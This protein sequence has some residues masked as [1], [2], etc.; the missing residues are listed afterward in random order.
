MSTREALDALAFG[1]ARGAD[2]LWLG[3]GDATLRKDLLAIVSAAKI[4]GYVRIKLQTNGM[5]LSYADYARRAIEAGITEVSFSIKAATAETHD[6]YTLTPG[7]HALMLQGIER[8]R[9]AGLLLEA[10][11]LV[12]RGT[13]SE[14]PEIVRSYHARGI[15]RFRIWLLS[16][17]D[18][19]DPEVKSEVPRISDVIPE[20]RAALALG[21]SDAPD[22]IQSLHTPPCT[23]GAELARCRFFAP[24]LALVV[25]NPGGH[26]FRLEES[27]I[28]G[29]HYLER[30][31]GC[32]ERARCGGIR[33]D[34]IAVHGDEEFQPL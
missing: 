29:G 30:C 13:L 16:A 33:V 18:R 2:A 32:R 15:E 14:L 22:F 9:D 4:M 19:D 25:A 5:L 26:R 27:P 6:R 20:L 24:D 31:A 10:D 12:Y 3:G 34:Y 23:L 11:V 17:V 8:M 28:E 1:R 7:C 21:L